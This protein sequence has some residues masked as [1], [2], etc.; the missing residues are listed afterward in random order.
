MPD[1]STE[2]WRTVRYEVDEFEDSFLW[3]VARE[4]L[5][6]KRNSY[7]STLDNPKSPDNMTNYARG[8]RSALLYATMLMRHLKRQADNHLKPRSKKDDEDG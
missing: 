4:H 8:C 6:E 1:L 5:E 2:E 3:G 7:L